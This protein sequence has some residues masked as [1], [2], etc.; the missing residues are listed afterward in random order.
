MN[1]L[2]AW[3]LLQWFEAI[4]A[5]SVIIPYQIGLITIG[6]EPSKAIS[7]WSS[8]EKE[9]VLIVKNKEEIMP[10]YIASFFLWH[11]M[12]SILFAI[13]AITIER[14]CA[15]LFMED[16]ESRSRRYIPIILIIITNAITIP[17]SYFVLHNRLSLLLSYSQ[18]VANG[19]FVFFGYFALWRINLYWRR[20]MSSTKPGDHDKYSLGRKFQIEEN[21]RS[22]QLAKKL[23]I[24]SLT[25]ILFTLV[26]L[27]FSTLQ[28]VPQLNFIYVHYMDN[29]I[30]LAAFV[31]SVTLLFCSR[32]WRRKFKNDLPFVHN[33]LN[34][35]VSQSNL[36]ILL[37]NKDSETY[38][39]QLKH[40]WA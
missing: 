13:V 31:M 28:I 8:I 22:L 10:L 20:K 29:C 3:F 24:A 1:F 17:Y 9:D 7:S 33:F 35:R 2:M 40:A 19:T 5:K 16:Y 11:Y 37:S 15:T 26:I 25:Y 34:T 30:L 12:A 23:V 27:V 21:I 6:I 38:F 32:S 36:L 39:E 4:L 18:G 14:G